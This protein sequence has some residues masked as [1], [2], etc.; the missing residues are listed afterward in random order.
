MKELKIVINV[1]AFCFFISSQKSIAQI[2]YKDSFYHLSGPEKRWVFF[3]LFIAKKAYRLTQEAR[4]V[5]KEMTTGNILDSDENGG[6][7]DAFRHA[8]WMAL[9]SQHMCWRKARRLGKAHEKGNY[10]AF[11][12][13][14]LEEGALTDSIS[15]VMDLYNNERGIEIGRTNKK[16]PKGELIKAIQDS[17]T[18][19]KMTIIRKGKNGESIDCDGNKIN[20]K[21]YQNQWNVPKC[22]VESDFGR[23]P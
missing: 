4:E 10:K 6:Q 1:V 13:G 17:V 19:G 2:N 22:L 11:R 21:E 8:Y 20:T 16:W 5:S 9:L 14:Q 15:S 12:K 3:H 18:S 23:Q 7:V